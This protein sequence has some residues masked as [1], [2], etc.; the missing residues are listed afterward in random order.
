MSFSRWWLAIGAFFSLGIGISYYAF[1]EGSELPKFR[2]L[3]REGEYLQNAEVSSISLQE[4]IFI[5]RELI[6]GLLGS[7]RAVA[8][9]GDD[10]DQLR[11][12]YGEL[13][14]ISSRE[15]IQ[16]IEW[17]SARNRFDG[18]IAVAAARVALKYEE[19]NLVE[20][21]VLSS[22]KVPR[23]E[24]LRLQVEV[25]GLAIV[26]AEFRERRAG[27]DQAYYQMLFDDISVLHRR[28]FASRETYLENLIQL[29]QANEALTTEKK[30]LA[31]TRQAHEIVRRQTL[32]LL[33]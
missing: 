28:E 1:A 5:R 19:I 16:R 3:P 17:R 21:R 33:R 14:Q 13:S 30:R 8:M 11:S 6:E 29:K 2:E 24:L 4:D 10:F 32:D 15:D 31:M 27:L 18:D 26:L 9:I 12:I 22:E 25:R 7:G 20:L 23:Q